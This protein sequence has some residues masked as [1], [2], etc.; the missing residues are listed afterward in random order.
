MERRVALKNIAFIVGSAITL[1]AWAR[2]LGQLTSGTEVNAV[3]N[4]LLTSVVDT[5][6]PATN[7]PGAKALG[8]PALIQKILADCYEKDVVDSFY[9]GMAWVNEKASTD[10]S[11]PFASCTTEQ[12]LAI[13]KQAQAENIESDQYKFMKMA[14]ELTILGYTS[15]KYYV[16]NISK[17]VMMPGHYYGNVPVNFNGTKHAKA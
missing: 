12:K 2:G 9:K 15:S 17:Y 16:T 7:T 6:V 10:N 3:D 4:P 1:P 8:V 13:L 14:K 11:K 5:I